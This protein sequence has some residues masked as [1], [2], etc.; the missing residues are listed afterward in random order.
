MQAHV[1]V[2]GME[3]LKIKLQRLGHSVNTTVDEG[4]KVAGEPMRQAASANAPR[5]KTGKLAEGIKLVKSGKHE[6]SIGPSGV[7]YGY[8]QEFGPITGKKQWRFKPY[9]RPAYEQERQPTVSRFSE[10]M[11]RI[12]EGAAR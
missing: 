7:R 1:T 2:Q 5:G 9:L 12:I 10:F 4:L 3:E 6:V 8:F 11:K